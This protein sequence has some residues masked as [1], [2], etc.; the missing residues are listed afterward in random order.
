MYRLCEDFSTFGYNV[1]KYVLAVLALGR[2]PYPPAPA[3]AKAGAV[4]GTTAGVEL[5]F[6]LA[7]GSPQTFTTFPGQGLRLLSCVSH[8]IRATVALC[9]AFLF[10][11][12]EAVISH[13]C[14]SHEPFAPQ[15]QNS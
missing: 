11:A 1:K 2:T 14:S 8:T 12:F 13:P 3:F 4:P 15:L 5:V 7:F 10:K 6:S 9:H